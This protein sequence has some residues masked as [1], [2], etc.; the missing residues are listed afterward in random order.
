VVITD[1]VMPGL[2]GLGLLQRLR[3]DVAAAAVVLLTGQGSIDSA[4]AAIKAGA[5]DYLEKPVDPARLRVVLDRAVE[6]TETARELSLLRRQ[7]RDRGAFG[8]L[9][10]GAPAMREVIRQVELVAPTDATV[11]LTGESGTGKE[12]VARTLHEHSPRHRAPFVAINCAAIPESLLESELFGYEKGAFTGAAARR[13]GYFELAH[14]GTLFLDEVAEMQPGVQAKLLRVLQEGGLRRLGGAAEIRVDVRV[15]AATN[16]DPE[17]AVREGRLREDLYYRLNVFGIAL[18]PLRERL[19]DL[20]ELVRTFLEEFNP[21]HQRAVR[22]LDDGVLAAFGRYPWPGNIR[23]LR[24]VVE[25]AVILCG[26]DVV[27]LAHLPPALAGPAG[28]PPPEAPDADE[29]APEVRVPVGTTV[30]EAERQLILRTLAHAGNNKTRAA[31]VLGIS[32]KTLHNKLHRYARPAGT[33]GH[34]EARPP[35]TR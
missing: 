29:G 27:G 20:P 10:A 23:E 21:R 8:R 4:V 28:L 2:D 14:G 11:L 32:L 3:Q 22:G 33:P 5:Y 17:R 18:P 34:L 30:D 24:N 35:P 16:Q 9:V 1:L 13:V 15:V 7:L 12:L 6:R 25:R 19:E 31:E 26:G